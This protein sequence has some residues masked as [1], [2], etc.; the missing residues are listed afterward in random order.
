MGRCKQKR[1]C[2]ESNKE[3]FSMCSQLCKPHES[4]KILWK[5]KNNL[6]D[7]KSIDSLKKKSQEMEKLLIHKN[8]I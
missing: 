7:K 8:F 1:L 3:K 2:N 4:N 6:S 5:I